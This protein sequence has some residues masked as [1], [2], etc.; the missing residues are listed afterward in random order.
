MVW[1]TVLVARDV[2]I[3]RL[4]A[5]AEDT[6][7]PMWEYVFHDLP[8]YMPW[9][10]GVGTYIDVYQLNEPSGLLRP[11]YSNHAHNDWLEVLYTAGFPGAILAIAAIFIWLTGA[12]QARRGLGMPF[13]ISRTGLVML[14][15]L[16]IA[17]AADYPVRTPL[18]SAVAALAAIWS[19][20][21]KR[22]RDEA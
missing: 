1:L 17:S 11:L 22:F 21:Y 4:D 14:L 8:K 10:S 15:L 19:A 12:W 2:A 3:S 5:D 16:A 20:S 18:L 13:I 7:Y 9:G 6:R